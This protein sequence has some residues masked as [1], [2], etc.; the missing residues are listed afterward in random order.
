MKI[1]AE[2]DQQIIKMKTENTQAMSKLTG[3]ITD[4]KKSQKAWEDE[5]KRL[6]ETVDDLS[7]KIQLFDIVE[8][9]NI[10]IYRSILKPPSFAYHTVIG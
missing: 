7:R 1:R 3:T 6:E 10:Y 5:K 8:Q 2:T 4:R 9:V